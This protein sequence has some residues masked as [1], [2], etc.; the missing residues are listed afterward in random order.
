VNPGSFSLPTFGF[1][2]PW[3]GNDAPANSHAKARRPHFE[4]V[5]A[6]V[7]SGKFVAAQK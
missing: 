2:L 4:A 3:N 7:E 1:L 6:R 5:G